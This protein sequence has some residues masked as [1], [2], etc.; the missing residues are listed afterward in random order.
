[1]SYKLTKCELFN[2]PNSF[3]AI[4]QWI[5]AHNPD[6]KIHL[7]TLQGMMINTIVEQYVK[8]NLTIK[9]PDE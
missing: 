6:E 1:M 4:N 7:Y 8:G 9:I 3:E 2:T 5:E